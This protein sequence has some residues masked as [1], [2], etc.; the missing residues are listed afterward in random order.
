MVIF[1]MLKYNEV[2]EMFYKLLITDLESTC[3]SKG[4]EPKNFF[5]EIIEI[6][7]TLFNFKTMK[8]ESEFQTFVKPVLFPILSDF[9]T[10]LTHITSED[11][12]KGIQL[13]YA[14]E[15]YQQMYDASNTIL[16]S[17]GNYDPRQIKRVCDRFG[18]LYPFQQKH[19][20]IKQ[21]FAKFYNQIEGNHK[22]PSKGIGMDRALDYLNI[23]LDGTH[24]RAMDDTINIEK[25]VI[26]MI[27]DGWNPILDI[28]NP[29][30]KI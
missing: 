5:S 18:H 2:K 8:R 10:N 3:F 13:K 19:V 26:R 7:A 27:Q 12:V 23:L 28:H 20:N 4:F 24:H 14:I 15:K 22:F 30:S 1:I 16:A 29:F 17:W 9:C 11:V 6:G 25:I 21:S